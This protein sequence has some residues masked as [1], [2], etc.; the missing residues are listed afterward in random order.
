[1]AVWRKAHSQ[2]ILFEQIMHE[3][4]DP[5][6]GAS[7]LSEIIL[8]GQD[9]LVNVLGVVLGVAAATSD[10]RIVLASGLAA[11]FAE[12]VS[13]AAVAYTSTV[14]EAAVYESEREREHRHILQYPNVEKE[15]IRSLYRG[16][17]FEGDL[18]E[19]TVETITA[20]PEVWVS[21]MLAEEHCLPPVDRNSALRKAMVVGLS[22]V[23]G[24]LI[25]LGPF[26]LLPAG[27]G[28]AASLVVTALAL[29]GVGVYKARTTVGRPGR[30][31]L[32]M[33]AIGTISAM[34]GYC[35]GLILRVA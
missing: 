32:E 35:I 5:H 14:A 3:Q 23:I 24:S 13:M 1:M 16:K 2:P 9:G 31:G 34:L 10:P 20:N 7:R 11:T 6:R 28:M 27:P 19:K 33:A 22:S 8:G 12:S 29:F 25:P 15:E 21:V 4:N 30:S 26:F 17:G 18:L